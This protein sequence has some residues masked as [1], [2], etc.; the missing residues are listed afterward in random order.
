LL[1]ISPQALFGQLLIGLINGSFYA[2]LS[3]GLAI[4][5]G[6]LNIINFAHGAQ[7]MLGAFGAY[8]LLNNS[9]FSIGYWPALIISPILVGALGILLERN[10]LSQGSVVVD[11]AEA[12]LPDAS[13]KK[14]VID[15]AEALQCISDG[16]SDSALMKKY[17]ISAK[18]LESLF[19][20]LVSAG[21][22][23]QSDIEKRVM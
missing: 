3:L 9:Y 13:P 7:Y 20:K 11:I 14:P 5:F 10:L 1:G 12:K 21:V 17:N 4:I 8:F 18:G 15:A 16:I 19:K 6:L 23:D 22:I 2:M